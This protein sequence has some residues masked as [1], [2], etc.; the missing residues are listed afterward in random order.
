MVNMRT[1][2]GTC[3]ACIY[4]LY[5]FVLYFIYTIYVLYG[6][7]RVPRCRKYD[8]F[9]C[10]YQLIDRIS[11]GNNATFPSYPPL[12][13]SFS[14]SLCVQILLAAGGQTR[15]PELIAVIFVASGRTEQCR[16]ARKAH[17]AYGIGVHFCSSIAHA[18]A[19]KQL[20][21]FSASASLS[22][23]LVRSVPS[24]LIKCV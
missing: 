10:N 3:N 23:S 1:I 17:Q 24:Y 22:L 8:A 13:P 16:A 14:L 4:A 2:H 7:G 6:N 20:R 12:S 15:L 5:N 19:R 11:G 18:L 9:Q 21:A